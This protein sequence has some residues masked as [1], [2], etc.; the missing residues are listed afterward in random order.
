VRFRPLVLCYHAASADWPHLLALPPEEIV[1]QVRT[2][3]RR[4]LRPA[5]AGEAALR[6]ADALLAVTFDDA[7]RS[8]LDVI[9]ALEQLGAKVTVFACPGYSA[10][11]GRQW[12]IPEL[13]AEAESH[14]DVLHTL[15]WDALRGLSERGVEIGS[16]TVSHPHLPELSDEEIRRELVESRERIEAEIGRCRI[17]AY[18]FGHHDERCRAAARAA[19]YEGAYTVPKF[20]QRAAVEQFALPRVEVFRGDRGLRL[21]LKTSRR[22]RAVAAGLRR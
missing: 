18:P 14:P 4:G 3:L 21:R 16:H 17:L 8:V 22:A 15:D 9:P 6:P 11:G 1:R 5:T 10:P 2:L 12:R 7:L 19:G 13:A 20:G